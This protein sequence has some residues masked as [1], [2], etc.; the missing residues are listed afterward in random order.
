M[1]HKIVL[2]ILWIILVVVTILIGYHGFIYF[3]LSPIEQNASELHE[4]FK[5]SGIYGHTLG[6]VGTILM[7]VMLV[8]VPRKKLKFMQNWG[9]LD[10]WLDYHIWMG[11]M[12]PILITYHTAFNFG[13]LVSISYWSMFLV[14]LSGVLGKYLYSQLPRSMSGNKLSLSELHKNEILLNNELQDFIFENPK[15]WAKIEDFMDYTYLRDLSG[16]KAINAILGQDIALFFKMQKTKNILKNETQIPPDQRKRFL[17]M[18][19]RRHI[20]VRKQVT[21]ETMQGLLQY[22]HIFHKPFVIIMFLILVVHVSVASLIGKW[23][24]FERFNLF[25]ETLLG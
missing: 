19:K 22:W 17:K 7:I 25:L 8:Y 21:Y 2:S 11:N 23:Y 24:T 20:L 4:L 14:W 10:Y 6:M 1:L 13:G 9:N 3:S 12:G 15:A 5:P 16:F 18:L